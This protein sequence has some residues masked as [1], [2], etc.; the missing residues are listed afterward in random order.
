MLD[1]ACESWYFPILADYYIVGDWDG[2][3]EEAGA[4]FEQL[5]SSR[6]FSLSKS[7]N[8]FDIMGRRFLSRSWRSI[9]K[10]SSFSLSLKKSESSSLSSCSP[11][12]SVLCGTGVSDDSGDKSEPN[13]FGE[14]KTP[15]TNVL[16]CRE[17]FC[18]RIFLFSSEHWHVIK[19]HTALQI[20]SFVRLTSALTA[21]CA[22]IHRPA[23]VNFH[24]P[25]EKP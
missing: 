25:T 19:L 2:N 9:D 18:L 23:K 6:S 4:S 13:S 8:S 24:A 11:R 10:S 7:S 16:D 20:S 12:S 5:L 1:F 21:P 3:E 22:W 17:R 15:D 14:M